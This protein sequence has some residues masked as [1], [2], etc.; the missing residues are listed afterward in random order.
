MISRTV[1]MVGA[2]IKLELWI[3]RG[4]YFAFCPPN[5]QIERPLNWGSL[6]DEEKFRYMLT[7]GA[8]LVMHPDDYK[9][10]VEGL[11]SFNLST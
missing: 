3:Q 10:M 5:R 4:R 11:R 6:S 9:A 2:P 7:N 1:P 8:T